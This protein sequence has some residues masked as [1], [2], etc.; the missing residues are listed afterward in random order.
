MNP[1]KNPWRHFLGAVAFCVIAPSAQVQDA[2]RIRKAMSD[3]RRRE[4]HLDL[5]RYRRRGGYFGATEGSVRQ[6]RPGTARYHE[7]ALRAG[8]GVLPDLQPENPAAMTARSRGSFGTDPWS[9]PCR[10]SKA[11]APSVRPRRVHALPVSENSSL[12]DDV[13]PAVDIERLAGDQARRIMRQKSGGDT[14]VVDTDEAA[15]GSLGSGLVEQFVEFG[16]A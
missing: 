11:P 9:R 16:N 14:H 6:F 2:S 12:V 13:V 5:V 3:Y 8:F 4:E 15:R 10:R 7:K 1:W